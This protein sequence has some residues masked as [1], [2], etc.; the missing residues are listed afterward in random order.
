MAT[1][2][3]KIETQTRPTKHYLLGNF[4]F[5]LGNNGGKIIINEDTS[6]RWLPADKADEQWA[7]NKTN[8]YPGDY[9]AWDT[10]IV[11]KGTPLPPLV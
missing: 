5:I 2:S 1:W 10:D 4:G 9:Q 3:T 6:E 8:V 7:A 11:P